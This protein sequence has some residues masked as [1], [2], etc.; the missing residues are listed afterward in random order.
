MGPT[1][2]FSISSG[3]AP[4]ICTMMSIMGTTICGSSSLGVRSTANTP[5]KMEKTMMSGTSLEL[6]KL[7]VTRVRRS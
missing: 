1:T 6:T 7:S 5:R 4:G 2:R 3:M